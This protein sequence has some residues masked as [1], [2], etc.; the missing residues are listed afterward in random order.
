MSNLKAK[1]GCL[2]LAASG[3]YPK[4]HGTNGGGCQGINPTR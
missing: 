1:A 3:K 2:K 4:D